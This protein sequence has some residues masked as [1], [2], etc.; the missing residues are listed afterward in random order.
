MQ[1][2]VVPAPGLKFHIHMNKVKITTLSSVSLLLLLLLLFASHLFTVCPC[3]QHVQQMFEEN[4][5]YLLIYVHINIEHDLYTKKAKRSHS[6]FNLKHIWYKCSRLSFRC[7]AS[8]Q[9]GLEA[10]F[11]TWFVFGSYPPLTFFSHFSTDIFLLKLKSL[12]MKL[13]K[14]FQSPVIYKGIKIGLTLNL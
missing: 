13:F 12:S 3:I 1:S 11:L 10:L 14:T 9:K 4:E 5:T 8:G 6:N 7:Y 2:Q